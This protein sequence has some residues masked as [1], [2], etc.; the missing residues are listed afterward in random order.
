VNPLFCAARFWA[1]KAWH[2][3]LVRTPQEDG[4]MSGRSI[5]T[6]ALALAFGMASLRAQSGTGSSDSLGTVAIEHPV[7]ANAQQLAPGHYEVHLTDTWLDPLETGEQQGMRWVEFRAA[8]RTAGREAALVIPAGAINAISEA[9]PAPGATRV[10]L[11]KGGEFV[12]VWANRA[13]TNYLIH[14]PVRP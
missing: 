13:G 11:L 3:I 9:H 2:P 5:A 12:R 8:G 7:L 14:L 10:D 1:S 6:A 4:I